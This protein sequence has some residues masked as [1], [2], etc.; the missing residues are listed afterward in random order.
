MPTV[1][2]LRSRAS[3]MISVRPPLSSV[4]SRSAATLTRS[5]SR[6]R[7]QPPPPVPPP[8]PPVGGQPN[9]FGDGVVHGGAAVGREPAQRTREQL[10][11]GG[12]ALQQ[13]GVVAE[14]I[15]KDFILLAEQIVQEAIERALRRVDLRSSHATARVEGNA[16]TAGHAFGAEMGHLLRLVVFVHHE[17]FLPQTGNK[18]SARIRDRRRNVDELDAALETEPVVLV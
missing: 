2:G 10:T 6:P 1:A 7:G 18:P 11:I 12:P 15:E 9:R 17:I 14:S 16:E 4:I 3:R 5:S 13:D 8:V